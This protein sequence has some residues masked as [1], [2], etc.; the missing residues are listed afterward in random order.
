[1]NL[2]IIDLG[3]N[4]LPL[5]NVLTPHAMQSCNN[6]IPHHQHLVCSRGQ[7]GVGKYQPL[8]LPADNPYPRWVTR[9]DLCETKEKKKKKKKKKKQKKKKTKK[10]QTNNHTTT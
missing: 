7:P 10:K 6:S 9:V 3:Y 8:T 5:H 1:M 2:G 4:L